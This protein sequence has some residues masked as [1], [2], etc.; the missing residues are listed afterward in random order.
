MYKLSHYSEGFMA[1]NH[2]EPEGEAPRARVVYSHKAR[3]YNV[4]TDIFPTHWLL[5]RTAFC[6]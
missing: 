1:V 6:N 5:P 3:S 2:P 4:I